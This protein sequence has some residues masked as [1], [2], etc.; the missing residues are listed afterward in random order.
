MISFSSVSQKWKQKWGL[1]Y[2]YIENIYLHICLMT[3]VMYGLYLPKY[4][5]PITTIVVNLFPSGACYAHYNLYK[6]C[7][8]HAAGWWISVDTSAHVSFTNKNWCHD[9]MNEILLKGVWNNNNSC[10]TFTWSNFPFKFSS[11]FIWAPVCE[12]K[13]DRL[14]MQTKT[15]DGSCKYW[16]GVWLVPIWSSKH[17]TLL[18]HNGNKKQIPCELAIT[19]YRTL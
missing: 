17:M 14:N 18:I 11:N 1:L 5:V 13:F 4:S 19:F 7:W 6:V 10:G 9:T 8:W 15:F 2:R 12:Q 3:F 16:K